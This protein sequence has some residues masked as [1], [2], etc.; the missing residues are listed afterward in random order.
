MAFGTYNKKFKN[1]STSVDWLLKNEKERQIYID[2]KKSLNHISAGLFRELLSGMI[3]CCQK[4]H[5]IDVDFPIY[6]LSGK[7]DAVG[8]FGKGVKKTI[9]LMKKQ[10]VKD[11]EYYLF[12]DMRHDILHEKKCDEVLALIASFLL[13]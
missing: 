3:F 4:S 10:G 1:A 13:K 2:D 8:E 5:H 11:I 7:E 6:L 12:D 9:N